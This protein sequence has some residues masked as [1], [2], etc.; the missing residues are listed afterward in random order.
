MPPNGSRKASGTK[1]LCLLQNIPAPVH[2]LDL[3]GV[4]GAQILSELGDVHIH[5]AAGKVGVFAPHLTEN[6]VAFHQLALGFAQH[7]KYPGLFLC[8][9][10]GVAIEQQLPI[11]E[12]IGIAPNL[13]AFGSRA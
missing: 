1:I 12:L 7:L 9:V 8:Q 2:V 13:V 10:E 6:F 11:L 4:V 3:D 5:A